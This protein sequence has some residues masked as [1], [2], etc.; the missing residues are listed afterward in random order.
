MDNSL[1]TDEPAP[2]ASLF[3]DTPAPP[4]SHDPTN[5]ESMEFEKSTNYPTAAM[6]DVSVPD[7][8]MVQGVGGLAKAG[9]GLATRGL[10]AGI[11][12]VAPNALPSIQETANSQLLKSIG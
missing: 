7:A 8:M 2:E 6:T 9:A 3:T 5:P 10:G 11:E 1:F 12:A 4:I